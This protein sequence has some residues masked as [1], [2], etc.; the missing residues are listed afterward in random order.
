LKSQAPHLTILW[1]YRSNEQKVASVWTRSLSKNEE[2]I[3][4]DP[5]VRITSFRQNDVH[6]RRPVAGTLPLYVE[7][8]VCPHPDLSDSATTLEGALYRFCPKIPG[9]E[10]H[11]EAF[12]KF[13]RNWLLTSGLKPLA[14]DSDTS[15]ESWLL[16]TAYNLKR[17]AELQLKFN[18]IKDKFDA[19]HRRVK[20][21]VKDEFYP[22]YKHARAINS[23]SDEF[24]TLTGPIFQL[25]SDELFKLPYFIK[26]V[27]V[28]E[29]PDEIM[30]L[31]IEGGKYFA[32]DFSSFEAHFREIVMQSCE[33][34]LYDYMTQALPDHDDFMKLCNSVIA[35]KNHIVFK[36]V[37]ME[38]DAKRM[39]GEMNT[40]L[41]NGFSNL[42]FILYVASLHPEVGDVNV[43]IEGDD[44]IGRTTHA[45]FQTSWFV[46]VGLR[47]KLE[48]FDNLT[49]ASFCGMIFDIEDK[50][51]ITDPLKVLAT[52]GWVSSRYIRSRNSIKMTLLRCK[53]LSLAYQ[54]PACPVLT[55]FAQRVLFLTRSF[56]VTRFVQSQGSALFDQ[57]KRELLMTADLRNRAGQLVFKEPGDSTRALMERKFG[58]T[59]AQQRY[60]ED[61]FSTVELGPL[62]NDVLISLMPQEWTKFYSLYS[63]RLSPSSENFNYPTQLWVKLRN[64]LDT[65][66][67]TLPHG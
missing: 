40:S 27:P 64:D 21:F 42:M 31:Y 13:V 29:R 39:S 51:N 32:S 14:S 12:K 36:N 67:L 4:L 3:K 62:K 57:W 5:S 61:Y 44:S 43:R 8:A 6:E 35:G 22:E 56:N 38:I 1:G 11:A 37:K 33:F 18:A 65:G 46:D 49:E 48:I 60:L 63:A 50:T 58:I 30:K 25:I 7:G 20:S 16:G 15:V 41:G 9:F 66:G 26:Y 55:K 19:K 52:F 24:K 53:A 10:K 23:R 45:P 17:K 34:E 2:T 54:Y 28:H 59:V 47:V